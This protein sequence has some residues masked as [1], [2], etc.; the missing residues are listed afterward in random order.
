MGTGTTHDRADN[1]R[2]AG[3]PALGLEQAPG[4]DGFLATGRRLGHQAAIR[5]KAGA[6]IHDASGTSDQDGPE[7]GHLT[8][9]RARSKRRPE[10]RSDGGERDRSAGEG[11]G[12]PRGMP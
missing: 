2:R 6:T 5:A 1:S 3:D 12:S 10:E 8:R 11:R 4:G 7:P 9:R